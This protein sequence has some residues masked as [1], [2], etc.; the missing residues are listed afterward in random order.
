M[1]SRPDGGRKSE[2]NKENPRDLPPEFFAELL[3]LPSCKA[4]GICDGCGRCEH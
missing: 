3:D 1:V 2:G 4:R